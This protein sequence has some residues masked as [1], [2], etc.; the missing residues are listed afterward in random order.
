MDD[1]LLIREFLRDLLSRNDDHG[2]FV[3][4]EQ[5]VARGRLQSIDTLEVVVFLEERYG[6]DFGEIGFDQNQVGSV[7]NIVALIVQVP[8]AK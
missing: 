8:R 6:I 5:L 2:A 4:S 3:D 7:D 1:R